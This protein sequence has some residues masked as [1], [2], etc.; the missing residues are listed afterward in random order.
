MFSITTIASS[1]T[2][3]VASVMPN[4][5]SVLIENPNSFTNA[6]VPMSETGIVIVG[7][8]VVRQFWRNRNMTRTTRPMASISVVTTSRI[9]SDT[10]VVVSNAI[11][12]WSPA[13]NGATDARFRR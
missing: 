9:D 3:P 11:L 1:T 10:T 13:E 5:V 8:S 7:M 4:S 12:T 2:R 6:K